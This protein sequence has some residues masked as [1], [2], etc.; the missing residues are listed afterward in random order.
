MGQRHNTGKLYLFNIDTLVGDSCFNGE[1]V[2]S[3][4][5]GD[6]DGGGD[7]DTNNNPAAVA[8]TVAAT[9]NDNV[10]NGENDKTKHTVFAP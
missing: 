3:D 7:E 2:S 5:D 1:D 9:N 10:K 4:S 6:A 8:T